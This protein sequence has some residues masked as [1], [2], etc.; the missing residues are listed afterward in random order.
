MRN[1]FGIKPVYELNLLS[2][3]LL[4]DT[5]V[6][7]QHLG[8]VFPAGFDQKDLDNLRHLTHWL[9][10]IVYSGQFSAALS[11]PLFMKIISD[12]DHKLAN[13]SSVKKW[14][15][16]SGHDTNVAPT[17]TFLNLTNYNCIEDKY[18]KKDL[19]K[20]LNCED[21]PDFASNVLIELHKEGSD[22]YVKVR[23]NGK[24]MNLCEKKDTKCE[25]AEFKR[26]IQAQYVDYKALC[27][28]TAKKGIKLNLQE[29]D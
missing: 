3:T 11:T 8:R 24:Y 29:E 26:R 4:Y 18:E 14:T 1:L 13:T 9:M 16:L 15:M 7:D 12:F 21:G 6:A 22:S 17:L 10:I 28:L 19:G 20:Y 23:Y 25:Y 27:G 5:L 2:M